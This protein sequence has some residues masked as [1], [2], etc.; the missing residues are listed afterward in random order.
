METKDS[1]Q[2]GPYMGTQ[3][4]EDPNPDALRTLSRE[5]HGDRG[6]KP[7]K[8]QHQEK[9]WISAPPDATS[10]VLTD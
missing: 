3:D 10:P 2:G 1:K 6:L 5:D 4:P 9:E 8:Q 7:N